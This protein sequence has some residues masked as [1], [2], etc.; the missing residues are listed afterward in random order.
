MPLFASKESLPISNAQLLA[1]NLRHQF[2]WKERLFGEKE[3]QSGWKEH[4]SS[5]EEFLPGEQEHQSGVEEFLFGEE[6]FLPDE[7]ERLLGEKEHQ[8]DGKEPN[9]ILQINHS[10]LLTTDT[11]RTPPLLHSTAVRYKYLYSIVLWLSV[12]FRISVKNCSILHCKL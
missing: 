12:P 1:G 6:E 10:Y 9:K 7:Q 4:P 11:V 8:S 2:A 3:H 5:G